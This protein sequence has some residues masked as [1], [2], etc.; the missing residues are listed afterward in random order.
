MTYRLNRDYDG[1]VER[2]IGGSAVWAWS[3]MTRK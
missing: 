2:A 3:D 1:A